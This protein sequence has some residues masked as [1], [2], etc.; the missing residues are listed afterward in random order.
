MKTKMRNGFA[1]VLSVTM[2]TWTA[3]NAPAVLLNDTFD[4]PDSEDINSNLGGRQTGDNATQAWT[5]D[6]PNIIGRD[7]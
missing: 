6:R 1:V 5:I 3:V 7:R 2:G 4:T